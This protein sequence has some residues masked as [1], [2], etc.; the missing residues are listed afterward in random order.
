MAQCFAE[1]TAFWDGPDR[2]GLDAAALG[3]APFTYKVFVTLDGTEHAATASWPADQIEGNEPSV[4]L[5]FSPPLPA[6]P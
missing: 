6:L 3:P 5:E 4:A 1:G 2:A